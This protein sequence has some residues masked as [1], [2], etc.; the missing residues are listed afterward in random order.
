MAT[1]LAFET[2][3][4]G[5][6]L[7][8]I[9]LYTVKHSIGAGAILAI[10][11]DIYIRVIF[12]IAIRNHLHGCARSLVK[13]RFDRSRMTIPTYSILTQISLTISY[14]YEPRW[15]C[16]IGANDSEMMTH[17]LFSCGIRQ[18]HTGW[19]KINYY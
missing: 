15:S 7:H 14:G 10:Y 13:R 3:P 5:F 16:E 19:Y 6:S 2:I 18:G 12:E 11:Y 1:Y 8:A 17:V 9:S 4:T